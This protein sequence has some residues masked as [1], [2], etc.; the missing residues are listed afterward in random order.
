MRAGDRLL[1]DDAIFELD[2]DLPVGHKV[3]AR[4]LVAGETVRKCGAAIG[5]TSTAVPAG[6]HLHLHNLRSTYLAAHLVGGA[7]SDRVPKN[8]VD[9]TTNNTTDGSSVS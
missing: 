6:K 7:Q 5:R 9:T 2:V 8:T 4:D 1:I 3:A